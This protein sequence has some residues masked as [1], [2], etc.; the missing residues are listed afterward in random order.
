MTSSETSAKKGHA[1]CVPAPYQSHISAMLKLAKLLH[2]RGFHITFV[3]N[4]FNH[5]RLLKSQGPRPLDSLPDF[6]FRAI[7]DGLPPSDEDSTQDVILLCEATKNYM[8]AP[9]C[10]LVSN[11]NCQSATSS[12]I[13][14]VS[15]IISDDFMSFATDSAAEKFKVPIVHFIP[16]SACS[17]MGYRHYRTLREKGLTP[18]RDISYLTNGYLDT[19]INWIPG[20]GNIR[21][22]DLPTYLRT[23]DPHDPIFNFTMETAERSDKASAVI[24][25]TFNPLESDILTTVSSTFPPVYGVGPLHLLLSK[26]PEYD[27]LKH[28][29]S[30]LLKENAECIQWLDSQKPD[31]VIYVNYGCLAILTQQQLIEFA[32]GLANSKHPFL[33]VIRHGLIQGEKEVA[34]PPEF[35]EETRDRGMLSS[36]CPQEEVLN[37]SSI[38]VFLTHCGWNS[39]LE[40][41]TA[42]VPMLC[43][44]SFGDQRTNCTYICDRWEIGLEIDSSVKREEVERLVKELM[45]G[46]KGKDIKKRAKEW[47]KLA[48]EA[49]GPN[50]SSSIN[51]D[52][53]INEVLIWE[54]ADF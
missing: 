48:D 11:L 27:Q 21:L 23:T 17:H 22:M 44:P 49:T 26:V 8:S 51:L 19:V 13:P 38:G 18:L 52:K 5:R 10:D 6:Q 2:F 7:P 25:H 1:V 32:M 36:W 15:C 30:N 40:A 42:G 34:L 54:K 37:H 35:F 28:I 33:W 43:W 9:F 53:L 47:K 4:E 41:M 31:S 12:S 46:E 50:G 3:N 39:V 20:M 45:E 29:Q 24:Y 16:I 14:P